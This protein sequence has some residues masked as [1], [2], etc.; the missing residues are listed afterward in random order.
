M[1]ASR[2][3]RETE[4]RIALLFPADQRERVRGLLS[5]ECGNNL[6][7]LE[8]F[9]EEGLE[10][11]QFAALKLSEGKLDGLE[12]AVALAKTDWRDLLMAADFGDPNAHSEW[13][14]AK[15]T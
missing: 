1:A 10:R 9:D 11:V 8:T 7:L 3:S 13:L 15:A 6:P 2:L 12:R 5:R 4:K 14:P